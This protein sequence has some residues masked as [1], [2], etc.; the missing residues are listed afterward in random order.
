M[1][2]NNLM[3]VLLHS[4]VMRCS[5]NMLHGIHFQKQEKRKNFYI[6]YLYTSHCCSSIIHQISSFPMAANTNSRIFFH[7]TANFFFF[8]RKG[9][10]AVKGVC[11]WMWIYADIELVFSVGW[12]VNLYSYP[13]FFITFSNSGKRRKEIYCDF[14]NRDQLYCAKL[15]F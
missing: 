15:S 1:K 7:A 14:M 2:N 10:C 12:K 13:Y 11:V 9:I 4:Y 8:F 6:I 3:D 5:I